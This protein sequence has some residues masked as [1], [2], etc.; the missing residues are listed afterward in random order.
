MADETDE[1]LMRRLRAGEELALNTLMVRWE[2]PLLGYLLRQVGNEA[3]AT[4]LAE[5]T[6]V[7]L[8]EARGSYEGRGRFSTWLY[9]IA[10]NLSRNH[11]RWRARH[12]SVS[13]DAPLAAGAGAALCD[14]LPAPARS[15]DEDVARSDTA[16]VVREAVE[17]LP[18]E[19]RTALLL[20]EFQDLPHAEI[21]AI[22]GCSH[23]AVETRLYRARQSLRET[24]A[25][26]LS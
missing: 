21:G 25:R 9:T 19:Q 4:D 26:Q 24:L 3:V 6:F 13:L 7:R 23:K 20:F 14:V 22:L 8:Y 1:E 10:T 12:P 11:H 16:R 15:P 2:K 17:R 5:E 18:E